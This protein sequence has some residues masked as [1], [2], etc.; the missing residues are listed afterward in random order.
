MTA[1]A[2]RPTEALTPMPALFPIGDFTGFVLILLGLDLGV[3]HRQAREVRVREAVA[4][5]AGWVGLALVFDA[6]LYGYARWKFP[7]DPR[8]AAVGDF[9]PSCW[10]SATSRSRAR[11]STGCSSTAS[12][13]RWCSAGSSSASAP[14]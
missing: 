13:A 7:R 14:C 8:L 12:W 5:C 1:V 3:F 6:A 4:W 9:D 2:E 11:T 10:C